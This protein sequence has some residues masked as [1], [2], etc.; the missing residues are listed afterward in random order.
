NGDS[1]LCLFP[2]RVTPNHHK[3]AQEFVLLDNFYVESEVSADGHEWSMGAY[4]TDFVEKI[5]P[6]N[7]N[8]NKH[9]KYPYPAEGNFPIAAPATGYLWDKAKEAGITYRSYGEFVVNA[10]TN[11]MPSHT[12]QKNLKDHFDPWFW[13]FDVGYSDIKRADR[14]ISELRRFEGE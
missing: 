14:F 8:H 10:K 4:A 9:K 2:E 11:T 1:G 6:L 13:G 12:K 7:Y 5:W 3:L